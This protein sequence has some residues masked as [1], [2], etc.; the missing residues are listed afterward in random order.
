MTGPLFF[1]ALIL[2]IAIAFAGIAGPSKPGPKA[3]ERHLI[4]WSVTGGPE[5]CE[6]K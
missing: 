6:W 4:C 1:I 5:H 2:A 3:A